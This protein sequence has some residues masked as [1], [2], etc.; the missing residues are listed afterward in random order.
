VNDYSHSSQTLCTACRRRVQWNGKLWIHLTIYAK[1]MHTAL[2][3]LNLVVDSSDPWA[4]QKLELTESK[5][6]ATALR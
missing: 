2:P 5:L 6:A 3:D 4:A 1:D